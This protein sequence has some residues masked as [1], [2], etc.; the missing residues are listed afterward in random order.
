MTNT[1]MTQQIAETVAK[2]TGVPTQF[3]NADF[4]LI[5]SGVVD[6]IQVLQL[7]DAFEKRFGVSISMDEIMAYTTV[8]KIAQAVSC[9]QSRIAGAA[10][11]A[12]GVAGAAMGA[13]QML[14]A[15]QNM[16]PAYAV[17]K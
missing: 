9:A 6:S 1:N 13:A 7:I 8:G 4:D 3:L 16:K 5:D 11:A 14:V 17:A 10:G 15:Q 12:I 2:V